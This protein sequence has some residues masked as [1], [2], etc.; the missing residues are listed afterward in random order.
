MSN[1]YLA[2]GIDNDAD[3]DKIKR[4]YRSYC[5]KYHPDTANDYQR[6][7]FLRIQEAYDTLSDKEKRKEYDLRLEQPNSKIPI[8]F[9]NPNYW[10]GRK[11]RQHQVRKFS[12]AVDDFFS[13][14]VPG[15]FDEEFSGSKDLFIELILSPE[16]ARCGGNFPIELPVHETCPVCSGRGHDNNYVC[17]RCFGSGY[18]TSQRSFYVHVPSG[19]Y[20]GLEAVISLEGIGLSNVYLNIE[21][22]IM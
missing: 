5:K 16:E 15:F 3:L 6:N 11:F 1:Y 13:G 20:A 8:N 9:V 22:V 7:N 10:E 12:S 17:S 19:V 2:L 21:I 14:F 18:L 4:A